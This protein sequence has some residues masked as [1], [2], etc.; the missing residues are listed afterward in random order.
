M[1]ALRLPAVAL[2]V[3]LG[4]AACDSRPSVP[5]GISDA[6]PATVFALRVTDVTGTPIPGALVT[7][8]NGSALFQA[9]ADDRGVAALAGAPSGDVT[10]SVAAT[11]FESITFATRLPGGVQGL[12]LRAVGE[13][14]VGRAISLGAR[15]I[16]RAADGSTLTFSVDVAVVGATSEAIENLTGA[17]FELPVIDCG[18]GGPR[19]CASDAAGNATAGGGQFGADGGA[20]AFGLQP[21][22]ARR[23]YL[24][25][26]L[27]ERSEAIGDWRARNSAL[28]SFFGMLGG[29]DRASLAAFESIGGMTTLTV[30]GPFT[31]DGR[32]YF[33]AIDGLFA[34]EADPPA[35]VPSLSESIRRAAAAR[36]AALTPLDA[37]V[38]VVAR[39][40]LTVSEIDAVTAL[41]QQLDVRVSTAGYDDFGLPE[42]AVRTGGFVAQ[43]QDPRQLE[44]LFGAMDSLL[45][46]TLPYYRLQFR[47]KGA[48]GVFVAGGNAK[49]RLRVRVPTTLPSNGS[50]IS[51]DVPIDS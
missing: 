19:D 36:D 13:W 27:A 9:Q 37:S 4:M 23:P 31:D 10:M 45:A 38:L 34:P 51:F 1:N 28:K 44:M 14:A 2:L 12:S 50:F 21:P 43:Y 33:D 49:V 40:F 32:S 41:A 35:I 46:G 30:L 26:V 42:V 22:S 20:Q 29:N 48:P 15:M 6:P 8:T 39:S 18:W 25:G 11:Q 17:D 3:A 16:E 47:I 5:S 24:V 7:I